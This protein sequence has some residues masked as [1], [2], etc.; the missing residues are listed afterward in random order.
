MVPPKITRTSFIAAAFILERLTAADI[1]EQPFPHVV[2]ENALPEDYFALLEETYPGLDYVAGPVALENNTLYLKSAVD[3]LQDSRIAPVWRDF[4]AYHCSEAFF[5]EVCH[6]WRAWIERM[7]PDLER[8]FGKP[9]S[10]FTVGLRQRGK[11]A[12][13]ENRGAD[14]MMDCQ[15]GT[16]SAVREVSSVRG[17]HVDNRAKL[18]AA[19]LYFRR[20]DDDSAG[21]ELE[22]YR[23]KRRRYP[24]R[25]ATRIDPEILE[26][27]ERIPY[28]RNTLVMWL[29]SA[30]SI[31]GVAPRSIT[32]MPRR[33]VNFLGECYAGRRDDYFTAFPAARLSPRRVLERLRA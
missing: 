8:N 9:L 33:Y 30:F 24:R 29:N 6:F 13:P 22:I 27:T 1:R 14:V 20:K 5:R 10:E 23:L 31:H 32:E 26:C 3:V 15:F 17:P 19:L 21:A 25:R 28:G 11:H 18:F 7:H 4:F 2:L 12:N 16:S